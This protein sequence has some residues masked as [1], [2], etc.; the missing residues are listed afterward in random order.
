MRSFIGDSDGYRETWSLLEAGVFSTATSEVLRLA[1]GRERPR[2]DQLAESVASGR[3]LPFR[4][5]MR[6]QR[7][8]WHGVRGIRQ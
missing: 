1:A 4:Q 8:H 7:C 5:S 3:V 6:A 2:R